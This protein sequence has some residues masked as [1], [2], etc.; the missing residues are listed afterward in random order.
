[1]WPSNPQKNGLTDSKRFT[2]KK[3]DFTSNENDDG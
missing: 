3:C 2:K 1:M